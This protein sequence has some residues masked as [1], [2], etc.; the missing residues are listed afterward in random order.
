MLGVNNSNEVIGPV[1]VI[2]T[3]VTAIPVLLLLDCSSLSGPAQGHPAQSL[4]FRGCPS[5]RPL[6]NAQ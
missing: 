4:G 5:Q 1:A 2:V 3:E 6:S